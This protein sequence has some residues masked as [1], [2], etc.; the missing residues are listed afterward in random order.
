MGA[1]FECAQD[2]AA[3]EQ[4]LADMKREVRKLPSPLD[5]RH[6]LDLCAGGQVF[7]TSPGPV[8]PSSLLRYQF[9]QGH[10]NCKAWAFVVQ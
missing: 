5:E 8:K 1:N 4:E 7:A 10:N 2:L 9:V 6:S 3:C